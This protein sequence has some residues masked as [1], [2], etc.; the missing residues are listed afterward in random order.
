MIPNPPT[1]DL[2][3]SLDLAEPYIDEDGNH[4]VALIWNGTNL[5]LRTVDEWKKDEPEIGKYLETLYFPH[6]KQRWKYPSTPT[7]PDG[8]GDVRRLHIEIQRCNDD[9]IEFPES[10][11]PSVFATWI[12]GSYLVPFLPRSPVLP[13][14]GPSGSGKGQVLDQ[15]HLLGYRGKKYLDP[16][17]A[18]LYRQ[19][20]KWKMT[21]AL[22][23]IQDKDQESFRAIMSIVKGS[24]DGSSVPRCNSDS[25]DIDDFD[26][27]GFFAISF[28]DHHPKEDVKNRG[29]LLTMQENE[30]TKK[31]VPD[32]SIEHRELRGRLMGLRFKCLTDPEFIGEVLK[33]VE[34]KGAPEA[35][36]FDRRPRDKAVSLLIP[37]IMSEQEDELIEIIGKSANEARDEN[38]STFVALVQHAFS[39]L[40][41]PKTNPPRF[42]PVLAIRA[43]LQEELQA[44]GELKDNQK[45]QTRK[46]TDALKTL[47]YDLVRK[48]GNNP[49]IDRESKHNIA[50]FEINQKKFAIVEGGP[51]S[52]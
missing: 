33:K 52:E 3:Y 12:M 17:P 49:F 37:A 11:W 35:L 2:G 50:S 47:G 32:D 29:I 13:I 16:T 40:T 7:L 26:S 9:Y 1:D 27:R 46:V 10:A 45:L 18:V 39:N 28:K 31:L 24:Y 34:I 43:H 5:K 4:S 8:Y 48:N 30:I 21:F 36:G 22:D 38:N 25:G 51:R 15:I 23:E 6:G 20:D 14:F 41:G 44:D 19:A 42:Y